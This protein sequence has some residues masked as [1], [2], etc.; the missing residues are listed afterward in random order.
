[1]RRGIT[2]VLAVLAGMA[3][4]SGRRSAGPPDARAQVRGDTAPALIKVRAGEAL[5]YSFFDDR[6]ELR[7]VERLEQVL[8]RARGEVLVTD[9]R[10]ALPGDAV[11]LADLRKPG[12]G[13]DYHVWLDRR[14]AWLDRVMP[15][16]SQL[17]RPVLAAAGAPKAPPKLKKKKKRPKPRPV[18]AAPGG[19]Q[20]RVLLFSTTW[21]P[22]CKS[23]R[24]HL[25][26]RGVRFAELDVENDQQA[27]E[28]YQKLTAAH[29]LKPGV[30]PMIVVD[31]KPM[32]GFSAPQLDAVLAASGLAAAH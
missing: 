26:A 31:G 28:L 12:K 5:L 1:V 15:R 21:C 32:Q 23:A 14:G 9:P 16:V 2:W 29:G 19:G 18:A 11:Y 25:T 20:P 22:S 13:G 4:C 17:R 7:T 3:G 8:A 30:V 10:H 27:G 6:A 24:A